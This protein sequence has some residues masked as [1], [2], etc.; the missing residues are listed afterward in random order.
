MAS[1]FEPASKGGGNR[2][3]IAGWGLAA[4]LLLLPFLAMQVTNEVVWGPADFIVFAAMLGVAGGLVE[5][6][7]RQ[8]RNRWYRCGAAVAVAACFLLV[9]VNLAVGFLGDEG[10]AANLMFA[11]V[12]AVAVGGSCIAHFRAAGMAKAMVATAVA[13][14]LV[15]A[16]GLAAGLGSPDN[17]GV[18]EVVMGTSLFG[19]LWLLSAWL[20]RKAAGA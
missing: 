9:W 4:L 7:A 1:N 6:T 15:G 5:F 14:V 18:Y 13:Q 17:D 11:G 20:F 2:W 8:S 16:I 10:N 12:I 19:G 3:R